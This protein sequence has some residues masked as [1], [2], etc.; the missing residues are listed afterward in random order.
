MNGPFT[1]FMLYLFAT[2]TVGIGI[3]WLLRNVF[4]KR[5]LDNQN[6]NWQLKLDDVIRQRDRL[7]A[8]ITSLRT[9]IEKQQAVV[10]Q[11]ENVAAKARTELE[12]AHEKVKSLSKDVF[13]LRSERESFK[14]K[15]GTIQNALDTVKQQTAELQLEFVKS[16]EFYKGELEK[17][18][19]KR[20][21][22]AVK[23]ENSKYEH[24]SFSNL[25][26]ASRTEHQSTN[27]ILAS[28]QKRLN[29]LDALEQ[30]VIELEAENAQLNHDTVRTKQEVEALQRDIAELDE[31]RVQN[32]ELAHCLES[33][34][35]SR[36]QYE[37]DA[38][39]YRQHAGE[40]ERQSETLRVKLEDLEQNF[41]DME[42]QQRD[43]LSSAR[44]AVATQKSNG[45]KPPKRKID[46][47]QEIVG[48][49]KVFESTLHDLG[50][51]N[52]QQIASFG[53]ADI[54]RVN[55]SLKE[56]KGRMEQDDWIGQAKELHFKKYG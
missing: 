54:A 16:G 56:F 36:K 17:S 10:N 12:S 23:I 38:G 5:R 22:L 8:E 20:K 1:Q 14:N 11:F 29:D 15:V 40:S 44:R 45:Q 31:L 51:F 24:E 52:F 39:R 33:M 47:L 9:S 7:T 6:D 30:K 46:D 3:G 4:G 19:E 53:V 28:A 49:G 37:D 21:T 32:K 2:G 25:L 26:N 48:V 35:N 18:F 43:A 34:E 55:S 13:T 41:A 42:K 50:I 27:K